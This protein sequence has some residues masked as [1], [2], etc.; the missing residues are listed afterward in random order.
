MTQTGRIFG[1]RYEVTRPL[2]SGG[3]SEVFVARDNLLGRQVALK[4][5]HPDL[6]RDRQFIER[7][8]R[9]AQS[10]ASLNDPRVVAVYDWGSDEGTYYLVMECVEGKSLKDLIVAEG[11]FTMERAEE[12]V[13]DVC[14]ALHFAHV[15]GLVHRDVKP[16]NIM[17]TNEGKTKVMDFGIARAITDPGATVTQTGTVLGTANYLSPEQAQGMTVDARSDVYSVGVVLY[18]MLT[19]Q[20]PFKADTAVAIA[21]KHV[22]E[23]P[24]PPSLLNPEVSPELDSVVLKALAKHPDN[25]Y[26]S[27]DELRLDLQRLLA[28]QAVEA[29]PLLLATDQTVAM[30]S[31][32]TM[33]ESTTVIPVMRPPIV[34]QSRRGLAYTLL[35]LMIASILVAAGSLVYGVVAVGSQSVPVPNLSG[36]T[37]DQASKALIDLKLKPV[38]DGQTAS[39]SVK[40]GLVAKQNPQDGAKA[41]AGSQVDFS[42]S[43]GPQNVPVPDTTRKTVADAQNALSAANFLA[44]TTTTEYSNDIPQG[45]VT[46]TSPIA[47]TSLPKGSRVDIFISGGKQPNSLT[48]VT[49]LPKGSALAVLRD[50]GFVPV[51]VTGCDAAQPVDSVLAQMPAGNSQA[52]SGTN[53]SITINNQP[54]PIPSVVSMPLQKAIDTLQAAGFPV[55]SVTSPTL[56]LFPPTVIAQSPSAGTIA[57]PGTVMAITAQ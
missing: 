54:K 36:M 24:K 30:T 47:G 41:R 52:V 57:C 23:P 53:V 6:A 8:R 28:G 10:A 43:S 34:P 51:P 38:N 49:G 20:V 44:G 26:Q 12:V 46:R 29:T 3:M 1:G 32:R 16:A 15:H 21:Y 33:R 50:E 11:P 27:A 25:R 56:E 13:A 22:K 37:A 17:I 9:E 19:Q 7:F 48:N 55:G 2:A 5:L 31:A 42:I 4:I 35:L 18:E 39:D 45:K 14:A 40:A